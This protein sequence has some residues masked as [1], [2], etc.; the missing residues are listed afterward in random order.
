MGGGARLA[1][2]WKILRNC[3]KGEFVL[4]VVWATQPETAK[5]KDALKVSEQH[6]DTLSIVPGAFERLC[7]SKRSC[8]VAS[9]LVDAAWNP[10]LR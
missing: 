8:E 2:L 5:L 1:G 4:G 10:A 3:P 7:P 9:V 6:L